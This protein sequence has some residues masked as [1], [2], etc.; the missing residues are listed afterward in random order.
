VL[1]I[2]DIEDNS[3]IMGK[4]YNKNDNFDVIGSLPDMVD[5]GTY[6]VGDK[7]AGSVVG[8]YDVGDKVAGSVVGTYNV[9]DKVAGS[10]VEQQGVEAVILQTGGVV[11][12]RPI[13]LH[14]RYRHKG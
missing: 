2:K 14:T 10:V 12:G 5:C 3:N 6:D 11:E 7:V 8:T 13:H 1:I 4:T 9:C